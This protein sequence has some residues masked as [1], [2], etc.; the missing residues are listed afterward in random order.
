MRCLWPVE[1]LP[2]IN[3]PLNN[4]GQWLVCSTPNQPDDV[5]HIGDS[6]GVE[7]D[8]STQ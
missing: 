7:Y 1:E 5:E 8:D 4:F 2:A 6:S 3:A